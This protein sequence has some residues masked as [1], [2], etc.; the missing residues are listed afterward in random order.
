M[1]VIISKKSDIKKKNITSDNP[2]TVIIPKESED[3]KIES[4]SVEGLIIDE[5]QNIEA[6]QN[7]DKKINLNN[8]TLEELLMLPGIG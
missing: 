6:S 7:L 1:V 2:Q 8:A 3:V 5:T 4:S